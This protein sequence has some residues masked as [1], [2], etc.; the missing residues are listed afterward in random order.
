LESVIAR[1]AEALAKDPHSAPLPQAG[2]RE[3][4]AR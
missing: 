1:V 3:A 4:A 2:E